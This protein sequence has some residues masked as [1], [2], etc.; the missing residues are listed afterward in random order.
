MNY[1]YFVAPS[2]EPLAST[3]RKALFLRMQEEG[4]L[5]FTMHAFTSP[6]VQDWLSL[7]AAHKGWLLCCVQEGD[8]FT[9]EKVRG[10]AMLMPWQ[11]RVW[12]FDFTAFRAH[13]TEAVAMSR[14][15]LSWIFAHAPCDSV[16]GLSAL[17]N[18]HAWRLA[19]QAGF[20][21][22]GTVQGACYMAR[23]CSYEEG[24]LVMAR[25]SEHELCT[26]PTASLSSKAIH[27]APM[28]GL[29]KKTDSS[30]KYLAKGQSYTSS[31]PSH[32]ARP[33][34]RTKCS[35]CSQLSTSMGL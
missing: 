18:R 3:F 24:V 4:L 6:T 13:F 2:H 16:M 17:S 22:L 29:L 11:G 31:R 7:T 5:G 20:E 27:K 25:R 30:Q 33:M 23:K 12:T 19:K 32:T 28:Q 15:A 14:G 34:M 21:V 8:S 26:S 9:A 1:T 10:M 35:V